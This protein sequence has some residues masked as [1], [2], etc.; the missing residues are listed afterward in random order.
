MKIRPAGK[1]HLI[2]LDGVISTLKV[3]RDQCAEADC[4][5]LK[6]KIHSAIKSAGGARRH[7]ERRIRETSLE[8][9]TA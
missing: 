2:H 1:H 8:Y 9:G 6:K 5:S 3:A 4:P 7:M